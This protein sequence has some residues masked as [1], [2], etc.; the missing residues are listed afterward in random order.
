MKHSQAEQFEVQL[1]GM[2]GEVELS[3]SDDGVGFDVDAATSSQGLGLISMRERVSL[4][5]GTILITSKPMGGTQVT[6]RVPAVATN[7]ANNVT[8]G[9]A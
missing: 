3:V 2:P 6:V 8:S 1:R 5:N 7:E 4:V 9:A